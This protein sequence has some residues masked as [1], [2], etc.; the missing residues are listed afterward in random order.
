M[1][2]GVVLVVLFDQLMFGR[3]LVTGLLALSAWL[4][5][6]TSGHQRTNA[7]VLHGLPFGPTKCV[8]TQPSIIF[9]K[10]AERN[11]LFVTSVGE[12]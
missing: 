7:G 6:T 8:G 3:E 4:K 11:C 10:D 2:N 9:K 1:G 12:H 5:K